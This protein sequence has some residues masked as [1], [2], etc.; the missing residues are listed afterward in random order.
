M[1]EH[2]WQAPLMQEH[3]WQALLMQEHAWDALLCTLDMLCSDAQHGLLMQEH[4]QHALLMQEHARHALIMQEHA[5]HALLMQEHARHAVL[6]QE[7]SRQAL[8][9]KKV[10]STIWRRFWKHGLKIVFSLKS[11][12]DLEFNHKTK[13][14]LLTLQEDTCIW[15][16]VPIYSRDVYSSRRATVG[17]TLYWWISSLTLGEL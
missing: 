5:R 8:F 2:S 3:A 9:Y 13:L 17:V 7:D 10:C 6:M 15:R 4:A 11:W 16:Q 1:Q 12:P 14:R